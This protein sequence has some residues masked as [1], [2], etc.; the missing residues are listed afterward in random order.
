LFS[1]R[2]ARASFAHFSRPS[3]PFGRLGAA[4]RVP[5]SCSK[6]ATDFHKNPA[7]TDQ[8]RRLAS[9]PP[10]LLTGRAKCNPPLHLLS[11]VPPFAHFS[12]ALPRSHTNRTNSLCETPKPMGKCSPSTKCQPFSNRR[13]L[14]DADDQNPIFPHEV[15]TASV[16]ES[17]QITVSFTLVH[18]RQHYIIY[19]LILDRIGL[20]H[21]A[22]PCIAWRTQRR[23]SAARKHCRLSMHCTQS[24]A[25][26][27]VCSAHTPCFSCRLEHTNEP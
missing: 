23:Q 19:Y 14:A 16:S 20:D 22:L 18:Q 17:A 12:L 11:T 5:N 26:R 21:V 2:F 10:V 13:Q 6:L 15:Y 4:D 7:A 3:S 9:S 24:A 25:V 27:E 8:H 1:P